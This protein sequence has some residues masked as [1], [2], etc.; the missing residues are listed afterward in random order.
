MDLQLNVTS[1]PGN[2]KIK[3]VITSLICTS[4][5]SFLHLNN[6]YIFSLQRKNLTL[7]IAEMARNQVD[8]ILNL[9]LRII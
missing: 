9:Q 3:K 5:N 6:L 1:G 2:L 4:F 7:I 8:L